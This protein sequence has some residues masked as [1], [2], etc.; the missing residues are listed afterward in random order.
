M[1]TLAAL[2]LVASLLV[3][4]AGAQQGLLLP[5]QVL[6]NPATAPGPA[7]PRA[8]FLSGLVNAR[9]RLTT[10]LTLH[11]DASLGTDQA[12]CGLTTGASACRTLNYLYNNVLVANYDTSGFNVTL[13][14]VANDST[15][16]S[17]NSPWVGGGNASIVGPGGGPPTI[18]LTCAGIAIAVNVPLPGVLGVS[19][20]KC[21]G[22]SVCLYIQ[23]PGT[24]NYSNVNFG[25]ESF[26][27]IYVNGVGARIACTGNYTISGNTGYHQ[28]AVVPGSNASCQ[29]ITITL[30]GTPAFSNAFAGATVA[31]AV[32]DYNLTFSG[33]ATGAK[34]FASV[35]GLVD[36]ATGNP[37]N[38][39]PGSSNCISQTGGLLN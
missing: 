24:I 12:G 15:C 7:P 39:F 33:S 36:T 11:S 1:K 13:S 3:G 16:V 14:F 35:G 21:S 4:L 29:N 8:M 10:A 2:F 18:G 38:V 9:T 6:G 17:I 22:G 23:A 27:H 26:A 5:G 37:N 19:N 25:A 28:V 20:L 30:G 32:T 31:G 34:C